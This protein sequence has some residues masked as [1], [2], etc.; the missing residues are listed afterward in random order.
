MKEDKLKVLFDSNIIIDILT[1]RTGSD[2]S[3]ACFY[4]MAEQEIE[5]YLSSKQVTDIHYVLRK[6]LPKD[7]RMAALNKIV[8]L[9][10]VVDLTCLEI[11]HAMV[12][13]GED[14]ED[15][16]LVAS[17]YNNGI[18]KILTKDKGKFLHHVVEAIQ[19]SEL[20]EI[21]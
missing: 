14:F 20:L 16:V 6:Y 4:K 10:N 17:A 5:G 9:F 12:F 3:L 19:P 8:S 7:K 13:A 21:I 1:K 18:Y 11:E 2:D 15:N